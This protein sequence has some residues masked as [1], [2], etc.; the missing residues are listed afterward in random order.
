[1]QNHVQEIRPTLLVCSHFELLDI[2]VGQHRS[3]TIRAPA[4]VARKARAK[5]ESGCCRATVSEKR[6]STVGRSVKFRCEVVRLTL[7]RID[8]EH[9]ERQPSKT[10]TPVYRGVRAAT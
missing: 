9:R 5:S 1:M 6:R 7:M 3:A 4:L 8:V 2:F 10:D